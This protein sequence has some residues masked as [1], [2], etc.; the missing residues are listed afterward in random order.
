[1]AYVCELGT[2]QK[3]YLENQG[4]Q[5]IVTTA[6]GGPG[7]QQQASSTVTTGSWT[8]PPKAYQTGDGIAIEI[9]TAE[10]KHYIQIQGSSMSVVSGSSSISTGKQIKI[11]QVDSTPPSSMPPM[12]PMKPME[13]MEPMEPMK[14]MKPMNMGGMQMNMNPMEMRM[15]NM[16]MRMGGP[17]PGTGRFCPQCGASLTPGDRF[18]ASCGHRLM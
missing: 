12:E 10:G 2:N 7:Q 9:E 17:T 3:V 8:K 18:C 4:A 11:K 14:P 16:E 5:T 15:G 1:M 6:S 13:P